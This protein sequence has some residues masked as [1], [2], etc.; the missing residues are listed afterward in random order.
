MII[1][2]I[3]ILLFCPEVLMATKKD[4]LKEY[5][6]RRDFSTSSEPTGTKKKQRQF[7]KPIFVIQK[8]AATHLHYDFR[9]QIGNVLKSWA[10]PKGIPTKIGQK[11]L[12][13]PTEDHPLEYADFEGTIPKG[14][15][16]AGKVVIWDRGTFNNIKTKDGNLVAIEECLKNGII[17]I[18]LNGKRFKG[19]YA[20]VRTKLGDGKQWLLLKMKEKFIRKTNKKKVKFVAQEVARFGRHNVVLTNQDKIL[21]PANG[22]S[23]ID[24]INYYARIAPYML[25]YMKNRAVTMHRFPDGINQEG[26]YQKDMSD[27]F[28]S[29]IKQVL[30]AKKNGKNKY[31]IC[32]NIE[33]LVYLANQACITP[34]IWL[35]KIDALNL[36]DRMIFDLDPDDG[37][38]SIVRK[39][40]LA[41]RKI[42]VSVGLESFVMIT[43]SRGAHVVVPFKRQDDFDTVRAFARDIAKFCAEQN[44]KEFTVEPR[45]NKRK[46]RLFIDATRNAFA[47]TTVAPYAVRAK[48]GAPVATPLTWQEFNNSKISSQ[49][50]TINNIFQ[51]LAKKG[52][53]WRAIDK[54]KQS[55]T[56]AKKKF[57]KL[58]KMQ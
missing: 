14:D 43:G 19:N 54:C 47:Q 32:N 3:W 44:P 38:F 56:Q 7:K 25:P 11:R 46:G 50:F 42:L 41:L 10:V 37:N 21:F 52:D 2:F 16:G 35:S 34:H 58:R 53:V 33:T 15:Y 48:A 24:L 4:Q 49:S 31:V 18:Q 20:L 40:G 5:R 57:D 29:W 8:H 45:L 6:Q 39:A 51:R 12:A 55:L 30:I 28:P 9:I 22:I 27:Y 23:K 36:P 1:F 13:V 26:F 17:E